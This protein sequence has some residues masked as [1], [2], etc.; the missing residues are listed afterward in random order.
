MRPRFLLLDEPA[1]GLNEAESDR[2]VATIARVGEW[3]GCGILVIE[4]DMR[5]I[6]RLCRRIQ[7]LDYGKT[8][9]IG[10]ARGG[11][12]RPGRDPGLP[13]PAAGQEGGD[14]RAS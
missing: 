10:H 3:L 11:T 14:A 5:L 13:R 8:I 1:A 2:L 6:M 9:S 4:H 12:S 7:V